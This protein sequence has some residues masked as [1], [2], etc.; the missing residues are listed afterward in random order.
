M[1]TEIPY[2]SFEKWGVEKDLAEEYHNKIQSWE[3]KEVNRLTLCKIETALGL[4]EKPSEE[5][6]KECRSRLLTCW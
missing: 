1:K 4:V 6:L 5:K 2:M 3:I